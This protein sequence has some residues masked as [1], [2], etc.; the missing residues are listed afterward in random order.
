MEP[1]RTTVPLRHRVI[2]SRPARRPVTSPDGLKQGT[3]LVAA[4]RWVLSSN[5]T[6]V[7]L[8]VSH[9]LLCRVITNDSN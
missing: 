2:P 1:S 6:V 7:G 9:S 4:V 8:I 5:L 3:P